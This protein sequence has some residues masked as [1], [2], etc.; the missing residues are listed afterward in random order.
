MHVVAG[1]HELFSKQLTPQ[2]QLALRSIKKS[3]ASNASPRVRLPITLQLLQ[4]IR[5]VLSSQPQS[6]KNIM[7]WASCCLAFSDFYVLVSSPPQTLPT[8]THLYTCP[9]KMFP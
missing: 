3:Q 6:Y 8:T 2:L 1:L 7:L 5:Q 4:S 9:S